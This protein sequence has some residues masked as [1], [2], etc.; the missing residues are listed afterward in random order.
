MNP[1]APAPWA[2]ALDS[3]LHARRR[4]GTALGT[5]RTLAGDVHRALVNPPRAWNYLRRWVLLARYAALPYADVKRYR[6]EL[7]HDGEF[8]AHLEGNLGNTQGGFRWAS[9]LYVLVR[10]LKPSVVIETGVASGVSSAHILRALAANG[11]GTLH[12]IDLPNVQEGSHL[13]EAR[14]SGW[15]VPDGLRRRWKLQ[16]GDSRKLLPD[17]LRTIDR[18]DLFFHDSDHSYDSMYF[19][20][21]QAFPKLKSGGLLACD[22]STLHNAWD[23]FCANHGLRPNRI[24]HMGV[25]RKP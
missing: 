7:I 23:D 21:E 13:P 15:I 12:S 18:V 5:G 14:T 22:D 20:F 10:G 11:T 6:T 8:Q 2:D 1:E 17:L 9:E 24:V 16:L 4:K 25:T 19:E 3:I